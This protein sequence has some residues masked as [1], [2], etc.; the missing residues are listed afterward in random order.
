MGSSE[1]IF[2]IVEVLPLLQYSKKLDSHSLR[3]SCGIDNFISCSESVF[4]LAS[5]KRCTC[6]V[7]V[8]CA[9][10]YSLIFNKLPLCVVS[11][12]TAKMGGIFQVD[13]QTYINPKRI[14]L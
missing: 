3:I 1:R 6:V 12:E 14:Y 7:A 8:L 4:L 10:I 2:S 9:P 13:K 11:S 5:N